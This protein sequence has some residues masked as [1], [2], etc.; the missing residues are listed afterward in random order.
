MF[1]KNCGNAMNENAAVCVKCG[2]VRGKGNSY[3]P[4]CGKETNPNAAV[5]LNCWYALANSQTQ[6]SLE[7]E[8][9]IGWGILG[10]LFPLVGFILYC[11]WMYSKPKTAKMAGKWALISFVIGFV[12][13]VLIQFL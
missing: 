11:V 4:N 8:G 7:D 6:S 9:N 12:F 13:T 10:F 2:A 5:C 3:C 1:C